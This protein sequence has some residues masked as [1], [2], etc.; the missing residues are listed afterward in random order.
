MGLF[1]DIIEL[2]EVSKIYKQGSRDVL[3]V[4]RISLTVREGEFLTIVGKSGSGKSTLM[5]IIGCLDS[6][7]SGEYI[8]SGENITD[9]DEGEITRVR[10]DRIGFIFQGFNL[11]SSLSA[12]E[13]IELPLIYKKIPTLKRQEIVEKSLKSVGLI[14]RINHRPN[15]LSGGQQQRV[16]IARAIATKPKILLADEPTGNLDEESTQSILQIMND[17]W[18]LGISIVMITHDNKLALKAQRLIRL[19]EG[20]VVGGG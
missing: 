8:L 17:M 18:K 3:A 12:G 20:R 7:Y 4:D 9:L 13:N 15:Q 2:K 10:R 1:M 11:I 16:A 5:N 14:D 6:V 19:E